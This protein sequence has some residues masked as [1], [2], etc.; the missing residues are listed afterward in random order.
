[1]SSETSPTGPGPDSLAVNG[2]LG[3]GPSPGSW[4][5]VEGRAL[6][7]KLEVLEQRARRLEYLESRLRDLSHEVRLLGRLSHA[8]RELQAAEDE[9]ELLERCVARCRELLRADSAS[10]FLYDRGADE[11]VVA[12]AAGGEGPSLEGTRAAVG[13]GVAGHVAREQGALRVADIAADGRFPV[14]NSGRYATGSFVCVPAVGEEGLVAVLSAADRADR[15]PFTEKDLRT[16]EHLAH[17]LAT[18]LGRLRTAEEAQER[19]RQLVSKL[20]HEL[21]NPL[22]G[23]LRFIN[24]TLQDEQPQER[25]ERYLTASKRGLE[26]LSGIVNSLTGFYRH[27][28]SAEEPTDVNACIRQALELQEGKAQ[29]R[30]VTVELDLG[31]DVP[32]VSGGAGLFQVFTNLISN[33]YDAMAAEGGTLGVS[34][35]REGEE[36]VVR[37]RDTGPGIAAREAE[38]IFAP[39]Y[40]TKGPGKGMGLGLAVC[41][42]VVSRLGGRVEVDSRPGEG[43]TFAVVL[44][45][46]SAARSAQA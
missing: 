41:Q 28:E 22:D 11:L 43:T 12:R 37:V 17:D 10:V 9:G 42:E 7:S 2:I 40:T 19:H 15:R 23:V 25:R 26:R 46:G 32:P 14:R 16:A 34:T 45:C 4:R 38:R 5:A 44:P 31:D 3:P 36:V 39:F 35:R 21:R 27:T 20:A 24:L 18:A 8:T 1:M 33:A 13:E 29:D 6:L 30:R